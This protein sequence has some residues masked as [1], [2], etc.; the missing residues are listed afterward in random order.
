M[1]A[2]ILT[3]IFIIS[4]YSIITGGYGNC[5]NPNV[6]D[7]A[8]IK[9]NVTVQK[10]RM[11]CKEGYVRKAGTS[12]LFQCNKS[13]WI[14][15]PPLKCIRDPKR[16]LPVATTL[17]STSH[18]P[19]TLSWS[20]PTPKTHQTPTEPESIST[21]SGKIVFTATHTAS[22]TSSTSYQ[23]SQRTTAM[24]ETPLATSITARITA[25]PTTEKEN[26]TTV[27]SHTPS[28][29][30]TTSTV[31]G[32]KS[33]GIATELDSSTKGI[34]AGIIILVIIAGLAA[35]I[36]ILFWRKRSK[37]RSTSHPIEMTIQNPGSDQPL[38]MASPI[39]SSCPPDSVQPPFTPFEDSPKCIYTN[40]PLSA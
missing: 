32:N 24:E 31:A 4:E 6:I 13:K 14:N 19:V 3:F 2:S 23:S 15:E 9:T 20:S 10:F 36:A 16:P 11:S 35:T 39:T 38:I 26:L 34:T 5:G 37:L 17:I 22:T 18:S 25:L 28:S 29:I 33:H 40:A 1:R 12:N 21:T 27:S 30:S 7:N 8:E